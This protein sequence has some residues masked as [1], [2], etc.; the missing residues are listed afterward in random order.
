VIGT[1]LNSRFRLEAELGRG[2]M[3]AVYRAADQVLG[4]AVAV[5]VLK[6]LSGEEVGR[7]IK[8]EAQILARLVHDNIVRLY[9]FGESD[10]L[11]FLI[12]E[13]VDG[14]SF[15]RRWR[16]IA[17]DDRLRILAQVA[18]AL[19]YAHHQGVIHRD[20]K[21]GNILLTAAD[22]A[23]LSDFGLSLLA[24]QSD[25]PGIA[26]GTPQYMSPEQARGRRLDY[27]TDLYSLG[28]ILYECA[29][30]TPPFQGPPL[31][32]MAQHANS[33]PEPPRTRAPDIPEAL[34]HL[35]LTLMAKA[36]GDRPASGHLVAD[37]LREMI[38]RSRAPA[39]A[40]TTPSVSTPVGAPAASGTVAPMIRTSLPVSAP[41]L[42]RTL[43][44][45][46][47]AQPVPLSADE[48]YLCGHYLAYLLGGSRRQ[49]FL[50]RRPLDPLNADRARLLLAMAS[51]VVADGTDEAIAQAA[52]LLEQKPDVRPSL[53][54]IV[55]MKYLA[56]RDSLAKRRRFRQLRQRLQEAS[57][58]ARARLTDARGLLNPGLMPQ[59]LADLHKIA[60]PRTEVDEE[61]IRRWN[62]VT[63]IWRSN[64]AFRHAVLRYATRTA[65]RDPA[66]YNLWPEV[67]YPLI[68]R[69]R[70]QRRLRSRFEAVWD[71]LCDNLHLP[72]AG[73]QLDTLIR[74]AVPVEDVVKL[75]IE[76]YE[77]I[78]EP[79][80]AVE[81]AEPGDRESERIAVG[82]GLDA[83]SFQELTADTISSRAYVR[84]S[85]PDPLRLTLGQ[86]S[87]HW[88]EAYAALRTSGA[89]A[90][91]APVPIGPYRLVVVPSIRSRSAGQVAIQGMPNQKQIELLTPSLRGSGQASKPILA[92]WTYTN[93]S[94][95]IAYVDFKGEERYIVWDAL[96]LQQLN[97]PNAATLNHELFQLG[98][99]VPDQ[100]D[101]ALSAGFRSRN[102]V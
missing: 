79:Q 97:F 72:D 90:A 58:Y 96:K 82:E 73:L 71:A 102:P 10:G 78:D 49:G 95:V 22:Q 29:T 6:E 61:L 81:P 84:L 91:H 9:D 35:I 69:A 13:E 99:E 48:R 28:V 8:V 36:P 87:A 45:R 38:D 7:K 93:Q 31:A 70:W 11:Y 44:E 80:L 47:E 66:S 33:P 92:V 53:S 88:R 98:L 63:E 12:M 43:I 89:K 77:F 85:H 64:F 23:K 3:G 39:P 37:A 2:G 42:A 52:A 67:V 83:Q 56:G 14:A 76:G 59:Q 94:L 46:V 26:R 55:V 54:P 62:R 34:E 30:G 16:K 57:P 17:L 50:L 32:V 25:E 4:R 24:E 65:Y 15:L 74:Q 18:D 68:E 41:T 60:P 5:K 19:D 75:D 20:I 27:R 1:V 86:L 21:P 51:I 100:V 101:R 40:R